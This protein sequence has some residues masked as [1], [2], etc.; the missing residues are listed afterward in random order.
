MESKDLADFGSFSYDDIVEITDNAFGENL[1]IRVLID[2][3]P[4]RTGVVVIP[5]HQTVRRTK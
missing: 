4:R 3:D 5:G 2:E 1:G